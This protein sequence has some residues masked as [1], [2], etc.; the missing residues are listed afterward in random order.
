LRQSI[1]YDA[2][3]NRKR[4]QT[5]YTDASDT[6][7]NREYWYGY[8]AMNRQ[9]T[10]EAVN[11]NLDIN[12]AQGHKLTYDANGNRLSD[13]YW[14]KVIYA[15]G[16]TAAG[17][18]TERYTY[19]AIN[20]LTTLRR[21]GLLLDARYY[22][23]ADRVV[24]SGIDGSLGKAFFD[25]SGLAGEQRRNVYDGAGRLY[26]ARVMKMTDAGLSGGYATTY[27]GYDQAGNVTQY[28]MAVYDGSPYTNTYTYTHDRFEGY[29]EK[30]LSGT[31]TALD[32]G[33][34][35]YQ[36]DVNGNLIGVVDTKDASKNQTLVNDASGKI[37]QRVQN[38]QTIRS[39]VV[40][41]ELLGTTGPAAGA[42]DFSPSFRPIDGGN[43]SA[44][45]GSYR[46]QAGDTLQSIAQQAY[47]DSRLWYLV[48][49]ANGLASDRDLRVGA[50]V[51]IPNR[52]SGNH[53]DYKSFKPYDPGKLIGDTQPTMPVPKPDS[54]GGGGCGGIGQIFVAVVAVVATV[55]TA[56]ALAPVAGGVLGTMAAWGAGA[57]VGSVISQGVG[58]AIGVQDKFSWKAVGV[59]GISGAVTAG[60]GAAL[61]P[62]AGGATA[63]VGTAGASTAGATGFSMTTALQVAGRA[64]ISSTI[65]QGIAVATGLQSKFSWSNVALAGVGAGVGS[66]VGQTVFQDWEGMSGRVARGFASGA[67]AGITTNVLSG[68]KANYLQ[69]AV[70]AFGNALGNSVG[71]AAVRALNDGPPPAGKAI[72]TTDGFRVAETGK[73]W[74][75]G[76]TG[77]DDF[78]ADVRLRRE[79]LAAGVAPDN[80]GMISDGVATMDWNTIDPRSALSSVQKIAS[81]R[82][83]RDT[84][85]GVRDQL[86]G[87]MR[88]LAD[89]RFA[90]ML[91]NEYI[92]TRDQAASVVSVEQQYSKVRWG[93]ED[94]RRDVTAFSKGLG[95]L[96]DD[97]VRLHA[98]TNIAQTTNPGY[99][100]DGQVSIGKMP[101][102][103]ARD[104]NLLGFPSKVWGGWN[105]L[106]NQGPEAIG[107]DG[108]KYFVN[109]NSH[110]YMR[111][112]E[113]GLDIAMTGMMPTPSTRGA[114]VMRSGLSFGAGV[115]EKYAA[116]LAG[117]ELKSL[118]FNGK[119]EVVSILSRE[120]G[121][122]IAQ[123][124]LPAKGGRVSDSIYQTMKG[125]VVTHNHYTN[126]PLGMNDMRTAIRS[127]SVEFR[128]VTEGKGTNVLDL[129]KLPTDSVTRNGPYNVLEEI[130]AAEQAAFTSAH[131]NY[132]SYSRSMKEALSIDVLTNIGTKLAEKF[133]GQIR[134][135]NV[136]N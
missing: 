11:A 37:L 35:T 116:N 63:G 70:D 30:T 13:T 21:D 51:T 132:A 101:V 110:Q 61:G 87:S 81:L 123:E 42:D 77:G 103:W 25:R 57:M 6:W 109:R 34:T 23:G 92:L 78:A 111:E 106:L 69:V 125:N 56:G 75:S 33:Q 94:Y 68:G 55:F 10:V 67:A 114:A 52:V 95:A 43:P 91:R 107:A 29:R 128:A 15:D 105:A 88:D 24:L 50:T 36:Y 40:N 18:T 113:I 60:V 118:A 112:E 39:L 135:Y 9:T 58:M 3:G 79:M 126:G 98:L 97:I 2:N 72:G 131:P 14:D 12:A 89:P 22:D 130:R 80:V 83:P 115:A 100:I 90:N 121:E 96:D 71:D 117:V 73:D 122:M 16:G 4:V 82:Y 31:S 38:G 17:F 5:Q 119:N 32:P 104:L 120:T 136:P 7:R 124:M 1:D 93:S 85:S 86:D 45:P 48:A 134:Y 66:A 20:R 127:G 19:D 41:G 99:Q 54:G 53:N 44:S 27:S 133:P 47:G 28:S 129:S 62:V 46:I 74:V 64:V 26:S 108:T 76:Y 84:A 49:E 8:D 65:S 59:A 102:L